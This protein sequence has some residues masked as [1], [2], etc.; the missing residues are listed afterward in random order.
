MSDMSC[1]DVQQMLSLLVDLRLEDDD[2][3][4][5]LRHLE[6]CR[7]CSAKAKQMREL[8]VAMRQMD[9]RL[10]RVL[11]QRYWVVR[12]LK[13]RFQVGRGPAG[14]PLDIWVLHERFV[15]IDEDRVD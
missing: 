13:V 15:E 2:R 12:M 7:P 9:V 8:R 10:G 11:Q 4:R 6:D 5:T 14:E 1:H 3:S